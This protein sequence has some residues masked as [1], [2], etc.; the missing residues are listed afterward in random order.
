MYACTTTAVEEHGD[1]SA[2][3]VA[4]LCVEVANWRSKQKLMRLRFRISTSF[5]CCSG[6]PEVEV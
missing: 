2:K 4:A 6:S 5:A 1:A 3:G